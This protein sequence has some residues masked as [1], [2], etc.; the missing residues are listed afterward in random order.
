MKQN[1]FTRKYIFQIRIVQ[2]QDTGLAQ[3][4]IRRLAIQLCY[5]Q[6]YKQGVQCNACECLCLS[7]LFMLSTACRGLVVGLAAPF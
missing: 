3:I 1:L 2:K 6:S 7:A 4:V 5:E